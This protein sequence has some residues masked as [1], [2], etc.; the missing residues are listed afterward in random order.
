DTGRHRPYRRRDPKPDGHPDRRRG[1]TSDRLRAG[2]H[3]A[4]RSQKIAL[5]TKDTK[6]TKFGGYF[7][8]TLRVLRALRGDN[9]FRLRPSSLHS[10]LLPS[11]VFVLMR[12]H[13]EG[14]TEW[15]TKTF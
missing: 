11:R 14:E 7:F 9:S 12:P 10:H 4:R 13:I 3:V 8:R 6:I 15:L 5:T 2:S 1:Q